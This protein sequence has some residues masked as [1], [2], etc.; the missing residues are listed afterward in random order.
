MKIIALTD[1]HARTKSIT[2]LSNQLQ[3]ADLVLLCGDITHFGHKKE[4]ADILHLVSEMN[5]SVFAVSGNCDHP[6]AEKYLMDEKLSLNAVIREFQDYI[7]FGLSGS[8]P[9]P[10][11]TPHE[12]SEE[13]FEVI[14]DSLVFPAGKP[15]LMVSHQPPYGTINDE[16]TTDFH[17]GSKTIRSFIEKHQPLICFTGHIHEG[18][19][20]DHI[21]NT[22][23]V[24]PGPASAG[25]YAMAEISEG[26]IKK[27]E[28][29]FPF[30]G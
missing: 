1:I 4:M 12:Y 26:T 24:N 13:E 14:L 18:V 27:L 9:C 8:L 7:F 23:V 17:V 25:G 2:L 10:G 15:L 22:A 3:S 21:G 19:G 6:D 11:K 30:R 16:V 5:P 29:V 20:I 28:V